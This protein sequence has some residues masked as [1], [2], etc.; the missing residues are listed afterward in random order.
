V[1]VLA[2]ACNV[3]IDEEQVIAKGRYL[4]DRLGLG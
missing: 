3:W 2:R 4:L 1:D